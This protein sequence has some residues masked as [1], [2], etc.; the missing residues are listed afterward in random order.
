MRTPLFITSM[1]FG[2]LSLGTS[3]MHHCTAQDSPPPGKFAIIDVAYI[4]KNAECIKAEVAAIEQ[5]MA[6]LQNFGKAKQQELL[7][8][9]KAIKAFKPGSL[10]YARQEEK[11]AE[12]ES[13]LKL[14]VFR[15]RK[16]LADAEAGLYFDGYQKMHRIISQVAQYN[17]IDLVLRYDSEAMDLEKPDTVLRSVMKNVVYRAD[18]IDLTQIVLAALD[19][20]EIAAAPV[21]STLR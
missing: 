9:A 10:E 1:V 16:S 14:E 2:V 8:E 12:L 21:A 4:F 15:R 13:Q 6:E 20:T 18:T 11:L 19:K 7:N 17:N 3:A 5:Q